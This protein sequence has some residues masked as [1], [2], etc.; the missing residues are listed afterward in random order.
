LDSSVALAGKEPKDVVARI[1]AY[2]AWWAT[3]SDVSKLVLTFDLGPGTMINPEL[4]DWCRD[5]IAFLEVVACRPAG[6]DAPEDQPD[7][8]TAAIAVGPIVTIFVRSDPVAWPSG[9]SRQGRDLS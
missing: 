9:L 8:I 2:D 6:H 5:N 4:A 7:A 3:S 1:E